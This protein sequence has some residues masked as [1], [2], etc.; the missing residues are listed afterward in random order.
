MPDILVSTAL[1]PKM[2]GSKIIL[3][4]HDPMPELYM[5]KYAMD[6]SHPVVKIHRFLEK[7]SILFADRVIT[8]N[9]AF[10]DLFV[11]RS[12]PRWK[13]HIVMNSPQEHI[14]HIR[15]ISPVD[16]RLPRKRDR[17]RLMYHGLIVERHGLD[18]AIDAVSTIKGQLPNL[19]FH[20]FGQGEFLGDLKE[21][22]TRLGVGEWVR[23]HGFVPLEQISAAISDMDL[24]I[25]P[26]K[27]GPFT[28]INFPTRIFEYLSIGKPVVVPRTRGIC[29]YFSED[30]TYFFDPG[31]VKSLARVIFEA[32]ANPGERRQIV[33]RGMEIYHQH[34]WGLQKNH[35]INLVLDLLGILQTP[36]GSTHGNSIQE[37]HKI[38]GP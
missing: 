19:T 21:K 3:D 4:L 22:V 12:C 6:V 25:V 9:I 30:S 14:F 15:N 24:G 11:S 33:K 23:F 31:N 37:F 38:S 5:T 36:S 10:R 28:N 20:I 1:L 18:D 2:T 17:F 32:Y 35:L 26:N 29:D 13:I 34:Q 16:D 27:M 7:W 8:P